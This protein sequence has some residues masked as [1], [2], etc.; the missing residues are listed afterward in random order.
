[1]NGIYHLNG[2]LVAAGKN[3]IYNSDETP[4]EAEFFWNAV[5]DSKRRWWAWA[6]RSSSSR[7]RSPLTRGTVR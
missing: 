6:P 7:I 1:M 2:L 4:Q 3:L 5:A